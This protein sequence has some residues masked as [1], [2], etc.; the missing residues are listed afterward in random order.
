MQ[1]R[2]N[3]VVYSNNAAFVLFFIV[4]CSHSEFTRFL[5]LLTLTHW[6]TWEILFGDENVAFCD[7]IRHLF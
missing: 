4:L 2:S 3:T 7:C 1:P 6:L 5:Y